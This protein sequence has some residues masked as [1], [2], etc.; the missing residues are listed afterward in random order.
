MIIGRGSGVILKTKNGKVL[1][2]YRGKNHRW[3]Q[4]SWSEF[5]GQ[6]EE[7]ETPKEAIKREKWCQLYFL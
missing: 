4:D 2:Q 3:N 1:L 7:H 5:G 6:I